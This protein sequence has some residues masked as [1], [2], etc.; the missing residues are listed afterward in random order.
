M[1]DPSQTQALHR[2]LFRAGR[3]CHVRIVSPTR[4]ARPGPPGPAEPDQGP[5]C[6]SPRAGSPGTSPRR[7]AGASRRCPTPSSH[8]SSPGRTP[9]RQLC[10][11]T[12][13]VNRTAAH[14]AALEDARQAHRH[15]PQRHA[16]PPVRVSQEPASEPRR[17]HA[18]R[19]TG[20]ARDT[21][22]IAAEDHKK[23]RTRQVG[24]TTPPA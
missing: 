20:A 22:R 12:R 19:S 10:T 7:T 3:R 5:G 21:A 18:A 4:P 2:C 1:L 24:S 13:T 9:G 11:L 17:R 14:L 8:P 23:T 16:L 15:L 6:P